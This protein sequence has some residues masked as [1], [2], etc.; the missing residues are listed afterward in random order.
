MLDQRLAKDS[1]A[2]ARHG[3]CQVR[4]IND[5]RYVWVI[6][7]PEIEAVSELHELAEMDRMA[8]LML[9]GEL[10]QG[11]KQ[12]TGAAKINIASLGNIVSQFH[13]HIVARSPGDP[14]WPGPVWGTGPGK[15]MTVATRR[16]RLAALR[17]L[18][19][20]LGGHNLDDTANDG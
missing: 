20:R 16:W 15:P 1:I 19:R 13:L 14:A 9:A 17:D 4:L 7:V 6:L 8:V 2:A 5:D 12:V 10:G 3:R 18:V 11:L